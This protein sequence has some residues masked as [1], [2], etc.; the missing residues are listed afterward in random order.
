MK[1]T[2]RD[3]ILDRASDGFTFRVGDYF[4][5]GDLNTGKI[6]RCHADDMGRMW[7]RPDGTRVDGWRVVGSLSK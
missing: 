2:I 7:L 3:R 5:R 4:Y 6:Y 1:M